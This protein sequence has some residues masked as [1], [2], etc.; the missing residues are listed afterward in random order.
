MNIAVVAH[1]DERGLSCCRDGLTDDI[2]RWR[3]D[4]TG[5]PEWHDSYRDCEIVFGTVPASWLPRLTALRWL[6]LEST[7]YEY[8]QDS[9]LDLDRRG[10]VVTNLRGQFAEPA[11]E[12]ALAGALGLMRGLDILSPAQRER[13][14]QSLEVRPGT[15]L[16]A[17]SRAL[18]LGAG[19]IGGHV[20]QVLEAF[21]TR[22][23]SFARSSP[24]AELHDLTA[25]D[26]ALPDADLIISCLPSTS[27]TRLLFDQE[28][29]SRLSRTA[30][31]VNI[32]RGDLIDEEA[33]AAA[34]EAGDIGGCVLDV[35]KQEPLPSTSRL[36]TAPGVVLTQHTG[37]GHR[38]EL[39]DK[40]KY[41]LANLERWRTGSA[42]IG[43]V[44]W[45][46]GI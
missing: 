43:Q 5:S 33:L 24:L 35:T 16:L 20:R 29:L 27:S 11:T 21:G 9:A 32:G 8:Y 37:G 17:R 44:D 38:D 12:T 6:Q 46:Q 13:R 4:G 39:V 40:A 15:T 1:L 3:S 28:R 2:V 10:I 18:V 41:F 42:L 19:A 14:W 22:V 31:L 23:Q 25:L 36:W 7:G 30:I 34:L 45:S 26:A